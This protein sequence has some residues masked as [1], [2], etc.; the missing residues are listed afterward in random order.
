MACCTLA[1]G[2]YFVVVCGWWCF[3]LLVDRKRVLFDA[4]VYRLG[5]PWLVVSKKAALG[6][7]LG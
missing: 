6:V 7:V 3:H 5:V 1:E 2:T 4:T